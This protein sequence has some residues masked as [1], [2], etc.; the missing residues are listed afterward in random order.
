MGGLRVIGAQLMLFNL[1]IWK[2]IASFRLCSHFVCVGAPPVV[3]HGAIGQ[4]SAEGIVVD[5]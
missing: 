1:S 5:S 2:P 4:K 3:M